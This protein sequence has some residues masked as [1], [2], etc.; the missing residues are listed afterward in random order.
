MAYFIVISYSLLHTVCTVVI[1]SYIVIA[2]LGLKCE[3]EEGPHIY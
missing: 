3:T 2:E 1:R